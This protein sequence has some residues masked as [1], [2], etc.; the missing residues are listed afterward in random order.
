MWVHQSSLESS[1]IPKSVGLTLNGMSVSYNFNCGIKF[2]SEYLVGKA[3]H[4]VL[5]SEIFTFHFLVHA[6]IVFS[7]SWTFW[8]AL[9]GSLSVL[10]TVISSAKTQP[11]V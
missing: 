9:I 4:S 6:F 11:S 7:A 3:E 5:D 2:L 10:H 1:V 8:V